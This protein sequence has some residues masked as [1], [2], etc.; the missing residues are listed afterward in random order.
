[1]S[2]QTARDQIVAMLESITPSSNKVVNTK[3]RHM[4]SAQGKNVTSRSFWLA[5]NV[6]GPGV[7]RGPDLI[8]IASTPGP[9]HVV[10]LT[11][12]VTYRDHGPRQDEFDAMLEA[13]RTDISI[14]LLNPANWNR[15]ASGIENVANGR[16]FMP[17]TRHE[18]GNATEM[19]I[20]FPLVYR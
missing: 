3:F 16:D 12:T 4:P 11:L 19:K 15:P 2:Y 5:A 14:A 9:L 6:D 1:M 10:T 20:V 17:T 7:I 18:V 8:N 13:D